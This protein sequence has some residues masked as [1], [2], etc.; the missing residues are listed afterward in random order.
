[1]DGEDAATRTGEVCDLLG[2]GA[3]ERELVAALL[4][5]GVS[6]DAMER[7]HA[8]GHLAD[9]IFDMV[10]DPERSSHTVSAPAPQYSRPTLERM[11]LVRKPPAAMRISR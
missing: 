7:A 4:E 5:L 1:M 9:A 3:E 11:C 10:L 6:V 2:A 8:R